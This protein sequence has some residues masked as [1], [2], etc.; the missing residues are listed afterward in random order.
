MCMYMHV[1]M[2]VYVY[3]FANEANESVP[4]ADEPVQGPQVAKK[5]R[6]ETG[7]GWKAAS[8]GGASPC[9]A[10]VKSAVK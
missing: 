8:G 7:C 1:Y 9:A 10:T 3:F 5:V 4:R 2:C 6:M